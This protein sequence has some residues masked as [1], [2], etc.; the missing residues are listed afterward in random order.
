VLKRIVISQSF[1]DKKMCESTSFDIC[2]DYGRIN[3]QKNPEKFTKSNMK[4]LLSGVWNG[5]LQ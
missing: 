4:V 1:I 5:K 3:T 2:H